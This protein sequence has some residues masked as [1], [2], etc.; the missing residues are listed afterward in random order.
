MSGPG[1]PISVRNCANS[2]LSPVLPK[3]SRGGTSKRQPI[4]SNRS[5]AS[6][7]GG[8]SLSTIN[9]TKSPIC[10]RRAA[11]KHA[12]AKPG[13]A[14]RGSSTNSSTKAFVAQRGSMSPAA[15]KLARPSSRSALTSDCA[16]TVPPAVIMTRRG[17]KDIVRRPVA[18]KVA[19]LDRAG[20]MK[21]VEL[22]I[23][24]YVDAIATHRIDPI[25]N[26]RLLPVDRRPLASDSL[27]E[28][29]RNRRLRARCKHRALA[30]RR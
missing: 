16:V 11:S 27:W 23:G 25:K 4:D 18:P 14:A 8:N 30:R 6:S 20:V 2:S 26:D 3:I 10:S 13:S 1:T 7:S 15:M 21:D 5:R 9:G 17:L 28:D 29:C 22:A 24:P 19:A 12:C